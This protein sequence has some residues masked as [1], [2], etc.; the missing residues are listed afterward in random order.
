MLK[1]WK[2]THEMDN[3]D[4]TP[5]CYARKFGEQLWWLTQHPGRWVAETK[6]KVFGESEIV[7]VKDFKTASAGIRWVENNYQNWTQRAWE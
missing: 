1:D 2:V 7:S 3:E 4:G 6:V 5:T